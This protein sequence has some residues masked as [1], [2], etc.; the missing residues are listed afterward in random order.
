MEGEVVAPASGRLA[1]RSASCATTASC[2]HGEAQTKRRE[3]RRERVEA[4]ITALRESSIERLSGKTGLACERSHAAHRFGYGAKSDGHGACI[5]ILEHRFNVGGDLGLALQVI[6]RAERAAWACGPCSLSS[7]HE[8]VRYP[9]L[10]IAY[11][12]RTGG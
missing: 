7:T 2:P 5:T 1:S 11:R 3:D 8:L 6:R 10:A 9:L 12:H 4:R